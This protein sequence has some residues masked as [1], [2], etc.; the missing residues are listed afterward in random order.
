MVSED[1]PKTMRWLDE[2]HGDENTRLE[3]NDLSMQLL[4]EFAFYPDSVAISYPNILS[5]KQK[6]IKFI[7]SA[8]SLNTP[9]WFP[10][11][12]HLLLVSRSHFRSSL[13]AT[14]DQPLATVL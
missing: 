10:D 11:I 9:P 4:T 14:F 12:I 1:A 7:I 3:E 13:K 8:L 6:K 5:T 2:S